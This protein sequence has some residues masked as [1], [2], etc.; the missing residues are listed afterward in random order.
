L[1]GAFQRLARQAG[2]VFAVRSHA[3]KKVV[4]PSGIKPNS[5][6]LTWSDAVI[7]FHSRD[8]SLFCHSRSFEAI[9]TPVVSAEKSSFTPWKT[10]YLL[11]PRHLRR[12]GAREPISMVHTCAGIN[13]LPP[14]APVEGSV[15]ADL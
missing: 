15:R 6:R 14:V 1:Q 12:F 10:N 4:A 7:N 11:K 8:S 5:C 9:S 2:E 13:S 3:Y